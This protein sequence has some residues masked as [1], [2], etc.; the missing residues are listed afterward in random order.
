MSRREEDR[1]SSPFHHNGDHTSPASSSEAKS[2]YRYDIAIS[3]ASEDR[4][5]AE[6]LAKSLDAHGVH[7]FYDQ[8]EKSAIWGQNLYT[9][10]TDIYQNQAQYCVMFISQYYV[11]KVWTKREREAAQVRAAEEQDVYILPI[12]LDE[13][14]LPDFLTSLAY[15]DWR[16]ETVESITRI[17]LQKLGRQ[18]AI[19]P[20]SNESL[21]LGIQQPVKGKDSADQVSV[22]GNTTSTPSRQRTPNELLWQ[23]REKRGWSRR[24]VASHIHV[25]HETVAEWETGA[26]LPTDANR[27]SLC[28]LFAMTPEELG[29]VRQKTSRKQKGA[30]I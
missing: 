26:A 28:E 24:E 7:I 10:L 22:E 15:L 1:S 3:Y 4:E 21:Q 19:A 30:T 23:A 16:Q 5:Y 9:H 25:S 14:L 2:H 20:S 12:R 8:Y 17:I 29:L 13:T 27:K 18:P 11:T 6:A